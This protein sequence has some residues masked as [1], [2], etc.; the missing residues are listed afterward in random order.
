MSASCQFVAA[1]D[2]AHVLACE[3]PTKR[4][5]KTGLIQPC[6]DVRITVLARHFVNPRHG[7]RRRLEG[8]FSGSGSFDVEF[9]DGSGTPSNLHFDLAWTSNSI[10][11]YG[12]DCQSQ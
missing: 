9:G 10:Q 5:S 4:G 6:G 8:T 12:F 3:T 1:T 11:L 2:V 7:L